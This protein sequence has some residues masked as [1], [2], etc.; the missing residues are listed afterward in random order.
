MHVLKC[1]ECTNVFIRAFVANAH[2]S[3]LLSL[4]FD[5]EKAVFYFVFLSPRPLK[6]RNVLKILR[7]G[8]RKTKSKSFQKFVK[9]L[10]YSPLGVG[11]LKVNA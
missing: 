1:H 6:G 9:Q 2:A 11:G 10:N 3:M 7:F 8:K 4:R 5:F